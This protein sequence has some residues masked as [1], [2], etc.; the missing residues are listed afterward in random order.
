MP[1][2][3]TLILE[4]FTSFALSLLPYGSAEPLTHIVQDV[5][6]KGKHPEHTVKIQ[7]MREH[8][9]LVFCLA[10]Y[11]VQVTET[12]ATVENQHLAL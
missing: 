2:R 3:L 12:V 1:I 4:W 6:I 5:L 8:M 9:C 11:L 10:I 7:Q